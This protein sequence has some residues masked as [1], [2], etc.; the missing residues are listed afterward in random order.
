VSE[1]RND[2]KRGEERRGQETREKPSDLL[3]AAET[4]RGEAGLGSCPVQF[5]VA[6]RGDV[7]FSRLNRLPEGDV[8]QCR[9]APF[10]QRFDRNRQ[11]E[12]GD[13]GG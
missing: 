10:V 11:L 4:C 9:F 1:C 8:V 13:R 3:E 6:L 7:R 12:L 2:R 5:H